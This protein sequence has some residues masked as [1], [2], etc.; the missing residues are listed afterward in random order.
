M[1]R[2]IVVVVGSAGV[3]VMLILLVAM[4]RDADRV[5]VHCRSPGCTPS[6][7]GHL[8]SVIW[9]RASSPG[10]QLPISRSAAFSTTNVGV[11]CGAT[12]D[13]CCAWTYPTRVSRST[14]VSW[15]C[16]TPGRIG[17]PFAV[18]SGAAADSTI[19]APAL[20][21]AAPHVSVA[22]VVP[23]DSHS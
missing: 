10:N 16:R 12:E 18:S 6:G 17:Y 3:A 23:S 22:R 7:D 9:I 8:G 15:P 4:S 11:C 5:R 1:V 21:S 13:A 14:T 19:A 2:G 20:V